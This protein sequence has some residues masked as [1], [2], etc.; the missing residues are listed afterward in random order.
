MS[1]NLVIANGN[2]VESMGKD[3][4]VCL[5]RPDGVPE[6]LDAILTVIPL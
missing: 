3:A 5:L 6:L 1:T 2:P 4:I